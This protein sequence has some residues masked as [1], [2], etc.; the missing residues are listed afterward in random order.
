M[1]SVLESPP[2][3]TEPSPEKGI[4]DFNREYLKQGMWP[5]KQTSYRGR[6]TTLNS[7][8]RIGNK[9]ERIQTY[10][11]EYRPKPLVQQAE[12]F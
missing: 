10:R 12:R 6:S 8:M 7:S 9:L 3:I 1:S 2:P 5:G 11:E 4:K